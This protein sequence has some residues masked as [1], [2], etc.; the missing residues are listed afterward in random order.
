M[1]P[2]GEKGKRICAERSS[3]IKNPVTVSNI[4]ITT[5]WDC[6]I[7]IK[8]HKTKCDENLQKNEEREDRT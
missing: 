2:K 7:C 8:S 6:F 3:L 5:K 1:E 4:I